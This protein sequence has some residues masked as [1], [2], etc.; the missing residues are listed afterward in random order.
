MPRYKTYVPVHVSGDPHF[1]KEAVLTALRRMN[2]DGVILAMSR[3]SRYRFSAPDDLDRLETLIPYYERNGLEVGVWVGE[4]IGH[5]WGRSLP[6]YQ[7]M[8]SDAGT[9]FE[10]SY[11]PLDEH[12]ANDICAWVA[13]IARRGA[14]LLLIDDDFRLQRG[15]STE[16]LCFCPL[17]LAAYERRIGERLTPAE[18]REK[19]YC[20]APNR[21]R[22]AW[23]G[24]MADTLEDFAKKIRK[25]VDGVDKSIRVGLCACHS[26]WDYDGTDAVKLAEIFAGD[27]KPF[28]RLIGA[29]YWVKNSSSTKKL[30]DV[31]D[32]ERMQAHYT[33]KAGMDV[34]AEGDTYPRPR[35]ATPA[36]HLEC[37]DIA[38][39]AAGST[40][41]IL[42]YALDYISPT[43]EQGYVNAAERDLP[44]YPQIDA[45]FDGK[46]TVGVYAPAVMHTIDDAVFPARFSNPAY[47]ENDGVC[48]ITSSSLPLTFDKEGVCV[49]F[50]E[51]ARH[52]D[53]SLLK[54]GAILNIKAA[55]ILAARGADVGIEAVGDVFPARCEYFAA[56]DERVRL[57]GGVCRRVKP[58]AG[59]AVLSEWEDENGDRSPAAFSYTNAKGERFLV[60]AFDVPRVGSRI[61]PSPIGLYQSYCRQKQLVEWIRAADP[62]ALPAVCTGYPNLYMIEKEGD[63]ALAVGLWN[64]FEDTAY[65]PRLGLN[66][67]PKSVRGVN[68]TA[69]I[70]GDAV[71]LSDIPPF[72]FAAVEIAR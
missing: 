43:Y 24:L 48:F 51:E 49:L 3:D 23:R 40:G 4:T 72:S 17:H 56:Y 45:I 60:Y 46:K 31:I 26:T 9:V 6:E 52:I 36:S 42:K 21:Y 69:A 38:L 70:D 22:K 39:R 33:Q 58:K 67:T 61:F 1:P 35:F 30:Q 68:C 13:E 16:T 53:L 44:L 11:C 71:T 19:V 37:F 57:N 64:L 55:G 18:I 34:I 2:A 25:A 41:G 32:F 14:K 10:A 15:S 66:F 63:G 28:L 27:T 7:K 8:V 20:G 47:C 29:P 54:S 59:A 62:R 65:S 50:G 5:N 12:F